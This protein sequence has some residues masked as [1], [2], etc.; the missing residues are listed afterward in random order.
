ME[1][2][3]KKVIKHRSA[4]FIPS[5]DKYEDCICELLLTDDTLY[6]LEST[7]DGTVTTHFTI[8]VKSISSIEK[9]VESEQEE[10]SSATQKGSDKMAAAVGALMLSTAGSVL[11]PGRRKKNSKEY[12]RIMFCDG[13]EKDWCLH[14]SE[15]TQNMNGIIQAVHKIQQQ[16]DSKI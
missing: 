10:S 6:V 15:F 8:P 14:F 4:R 13:F 1:Y 2:K 12:L 9:Y 3:G 11:F 16:K 7:Y 5:D